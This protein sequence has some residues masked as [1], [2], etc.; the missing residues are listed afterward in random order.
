MGVPPGPNN[1]AQL[2]GIVGKLVHL[3]QKP[4][5]VTL[6][7]DKRAKLREQLA[8]LEVMDELNDEE[9]KKRLEAVLDIVKGDKDTL[10]A[11]GYRWP[12]GGGPGG[13]GPGGSGPPPANPFKERENADH[14]KALQERLGK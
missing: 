1:K 6:S 5:A 8:G 7:D 3:T 14:L 9:A 2:A 13:G 10:V 4:L 12:D 11:A